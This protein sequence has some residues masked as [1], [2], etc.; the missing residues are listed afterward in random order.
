MFYLIYNFSPYSY[1][2][3]S[4]TVVYSVLSAGLHSLVW[5][6]VFSFIVYPKEMY[7]K[8]KVAPVTSAEV[9]EYFQDYLNT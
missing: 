6:N 7:C 3:T 9:Q 5:G 2:Q 8:T 4:L 1:M